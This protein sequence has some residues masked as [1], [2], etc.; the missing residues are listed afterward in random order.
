MYKNW[1]MDFLKKCSLLITLLLTQVCLAQDKVVLQL[2]WEHEFQFA[3]Y[4]AA[5]WQGFYDEVGLDVE[6]RPLSRSDGSLVNVHEELLTG[7]AQFAIGGVD[8][9]GAA[10]P[11]N[12]LI[13][14]ASLFQQSPTS[15]FSLRHKPLSSLEQLSKTRIAMVLGGNSE[16]QVKSLFRRN[17]FDPEALTIVNEP[18]TLETLIQDKADAIVTYEISAKFAGQEKDISLNQMK[19]SDF[20]LPFYDDTLF[21]TSSFNELNPEIVEKFLTATLKGW[22]FALNNRQLMAQ[23]IT[24]D[25]PRYLFRYDDQLAYNIAFAKVISDYMLYPEI[26]I[27][28]FSQKRWEQIS[29]LMKQSSVLNQDYDFE[30]SIT[31]YKSNTINEILNYTQIIISLLLLAAIFVAW[32]KR[33]IVITISLLS[34]F[35]LIIAYQTES[36]IKSEQEQIA[37]IN[38][39]KTLSSISAK[40]KGNLQT[41]MAMLRSFAAFIS[42][43]PDIT[44]AEFNH[45]AKE[46]LAQ[47]SVLINFAAAP[48]LTVKHVYPL[49]GNEAVLGL[50]YRKHI[51]QKEMVMRV[52]NSK[53][54]LLE[55]PINL[56]QGTSAL[57]GRAPIFYSDESDTSTLW[58]IISTPIHLN[59]LLQES[60]INNEGAG[61]EIAIRTFDTLGRS[62]PAFYGDDKL[63]D[64]PNVSSVRISVADGSWEIS[65]RPSFIDQGINDSVWITRAIFFLSTLLVIF[66]LRYRY[67]Q[68]KEKRRLRYDLSENQQMLGI[69]GLTAKVAGIKVDKNFNIIVWSN[70]IVEIL[71]IPTA[72]P[73]NHLSQFSTLFAEQELEQ[74]QNSVL[75]CSEAERPF[76]LELVTQ[77]KKNWIRIQI[78]SE[79]KNS[80][81][82]LV[83]QDISEKVRATKLIEFQASYDSLTQLPNRTLFYERLAIA[84]EKATRNTNKI[85]VL[86]IDLDRFKP[87]NDNHGHDMGDRLLQ[88]VAERIKSVVRDS[89]TVA[90]LSGDEFGV[91]LSDLNDY[92]YAVNVTEKILEKVNAAYEINKIKMFVSVSVGI[93]IF[94]NDGN[95]PQALTQ[96][97]DQ[98]MYEVKRSGR[99]GWQFYTRD[100]QQRS[101]YRHNLLTSLIEDIDQHKL[102]TYYQPIFDLTSGKIVKLEALARWN[103]NGK[104]IPPNEFIPIAEESGLI[105]KIDLLMLENACR[106]LIETND[107]SIGLSVNISPRLFQTKDK[108]LEIWLE[109]IQHF[110]NDIAITV[111]MTERLLTEESV[112]ATRVLEQLHNVGIKIAID[113]FGTGYSSLSYLVKFPVDIIKID[114][115]FV[116]KVGIEPSAE[117]LIETILAMAE[118]MSLSV[119]AEGIETTEQLEYLKR[120]NCHMGQGFLLSRPVADKDLD[121]KSRIEEIA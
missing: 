50:D 4:Y 67:S 88:Q 37:R 80:H 51:E 76:D 32:N 79:A 115:S 103:H 34:V 120:L 11:A 62:S 82:I 2:K 110:A 28:H 53:H 47:N 75:Q 66:Y 41:S 6:I 17:G 3:G 39:L 109:S 106:F 100:M 43:N 89:D 68:E 111:E 116:D 97:A 56:I 105:N 78:E 10:N 55:G 90:R 119:I 107:K 99:N 98:A 91:I 85:A 65:A 69:V 104:F 48:N 77:D 86:F 13:I 14:L 113:D 45:F 12:K 63:F 117:S 27:G 8:I 93:S 29:Q 1:I 114:A 64:E 87:I 95:Q 21:T 61:Y 35:S 52:I 94:P 7:R 44:E 108:A 57:I 102:E 112:K 92:R 33:A 121:L 101:E 9:L 42:S 96:K 84:I 5:E 38:T 46:L 74:L 24:N 40:L 49:A 36:I 58:G 71:K 72:K 60:G 70:L 23:R 81:V 15:I 54:S 30:K 118:K 16:V 59:R 83:F 19:L 31:F 22:E 73:F 25:L 26:P 20:D 18:V